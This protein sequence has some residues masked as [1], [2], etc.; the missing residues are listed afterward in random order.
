MPK[1]IPISMFS[2]KP[3]HLMDARN[4]PAEL[5]CI[6]Q[7]QQHFIRQVISR[8]W[9][10]NSEN[11]FAQCALGPARYDCVFVEKDAD[12]PGF[13]GLL[14]A[15][16]LLFFSFKHNDIVYPCAAVTWFSAVGESP[17]PD[18][19]MWMVKPDLNSRGQRVLDIIHLDSI[20]HGAHL[21][22]I[23]DDSYL[24]R[25]IKHTA[26]LDSFCAYYVNKYADHSHEI[27]F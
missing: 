9:V 19:G 6:H 3:F 24:P 23:Y 21:I 13:R 4:Y 26:S 2:L 25:H 27:A 15:R 1:P 8:A 17:C 12:Q 11:A 18:V 20:L 14:A 7:R 5:W 22:P 16:V 10:D